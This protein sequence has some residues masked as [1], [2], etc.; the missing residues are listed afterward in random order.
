MLQQAHVD[1][2]PGPGRLHAALRSEAPA[3]HDIAQSTAA[4]KQRT[5]MNDMPTTESPS[6]TTCPD[7]PDSTGTS[8]LMHE[9]SQQHS[10]VA[11]ST[12]CS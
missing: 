6:A 9:R 5:Y 2:P 11:C 3:I 12:V 4:A 7:T 8:G 10:F 1:R